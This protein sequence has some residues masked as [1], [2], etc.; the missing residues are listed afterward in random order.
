[1]TI[2]ETIQMRAKIYEQ[3]EQLRKS[4]VKPVKACAIDDP[5]CQSCQ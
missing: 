2:D 1:M 3:L 5:T 4:G